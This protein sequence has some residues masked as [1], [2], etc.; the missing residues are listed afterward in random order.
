[1]GGAYEMEN[2]F[3]VRM[4]LENCSRRNRLLEGLII[5]DLA[6]DTEDLLFVCTDEWLSASIC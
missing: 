4:R 5:V 2:D 1:M 6:V 3:A